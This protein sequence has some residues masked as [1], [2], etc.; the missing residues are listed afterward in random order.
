MAKAAVMQVDAGSL[1]MTV[2]RIG[3]MKSKIQKAALKSLDA[4][5]Q[6]LHTEIV[7]NASYTDHSLKRLE[8][9]DHPYAKRHGSI[10]IH[11]RKPYVVHKQGTR[12][13]SK[14]LHKGIKQ[15]LIKT[16]REYHVYV[17]PSHPYAKYV[18]QG[19]KTVML[20]RDFLWLTMNER[21]VKKKMMKAVVGVLGKDMRMKAVV[22]F[23]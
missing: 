22:R 4:A 17:L 10:Q 20:G 7:K 11:T 2:M 5:G 9:L 15:R 14:N 6:I 3:G 12:K 1:R 13:H 16:K 18:I 23:D 21:G 8:A 19:T